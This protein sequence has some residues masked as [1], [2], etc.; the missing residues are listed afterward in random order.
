MA[1]AL[2]GADDDFDHHKPG[3]ERSWRRRTGDDDWDSEL[4]DDLLGEDMLTGKKTQSDMSDEELNDDLLQSDNEEDQHYS[5]QGVTVSLNAASSMVT[6]FELSV[7]ANDPSIEQDSEYEHGEDEIGYDKSDVPEEYAEEYSEG[8]Y[9]GQETELTEDQIGYGEDQGEEDN[10]NDEVLDLE[11]NE[12]LDE[13]PDE[14]F[15]QSY[16]EQQVIKQAYEAEEELEEVVDTQTPPNESEEAVIE[17]LEFQEETKEESDEEE[18]DDEESGR[19]RFKTERKE[20]TI[21]RLSDVTRE[22]RNIPETLELSAEAKAA[23]LEFEE[24]E[25]QLKQGRYGSRRGGRRGG[26]LMCHGLGEQRRDSNERG[27][28]EDHRPALLPTQTAVMTH[29][30][31][32]FRHQQPIRNLFQQRQQQQQPQQQQQQPQGLLPVPT[33]HHI[34]PTPSQGIHMPSQVETPRILMTPPSVASQQPKNIH[35]N[36]HF[37]GTVV[38]PVQVPLL[39]VPTQPRPAVGPQRF[40]GHLHPPMHPQHPQPPPQQH[41]QTSQQHPQP[42]QPHHQTHQSHHHHHL[43]PVPPQPLIPVAPSQFRLHLQT[44]Q[45]Q[46]SGNWMQC[47]QRQGLVKARHNTPTQS[48]VKRPNQQLQSS[49]PRNSNLRELPIA[50]LH[51]IEA[52]NNQRTSAPAAQVKPITSTTPVTRPVTGVKKQLGR[53]ETKPRAVMPMTQPKMEVQSEPEFPDDDEETRLYCLKIEEQKRLREEILKQKELRRQL[54]A[55]ARK[56]ELLER[57]AQQQQGSSGQQQEEDPSQLP[58]NGNPLLSLPG[59]QPRQNVKC[60]L[61]VKKQ[62]PVIPDSTAVQPK[63]VNVLQSGDSVQCQGQQI[64]TIKQLR[65]A[66]T[67][68]KNKF[69][70]PNKALQTK[71]PAAVHLNL[72]EIARVASVQGQPQELKPGL[73]RTVMQRANNGSGDGTHTGTKVRVIKLSG[74]GG[75]N[76]DFSHLEGLPHRLLQPSEQRHQPMRKVTLTKGAVQQPHQPHQHHLSQ[77]QSTF[78]QELKNIPGRHQ[79]KKGILHGRGRGITGQ[80]GRGRLMASKPNLRV[81]ECK[82]QPCIVSVEGL[83]SST[84]D[85]QLKNLLMSVGPIQSLQMLPQQRKA[86]AKF[87]EPADALKFQQKFHRYST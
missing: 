12:P 20:G 22:R 14:G 63:P 70:L 41:P 52:A 67:M 74:G 61:M 60:R 48:I 17:N 34:P 44:S 68:P 46:P 38:T 75:E 39:P 78:P 45:Q 2:G 26:S 66:R 81:V 40:A 80:M 36:P 4:D 69:Q 29:S 15:L 31:R 19:L 84:T 11:I 86:I 58:S 59:A 62:E 8:Q 18:E 50:P 3:A 6:S 28:I 73:K 55:G 76:V 54:Q 72:S 16:S 71:L 9:E 35:I 13:F 33:Q 57:L 53:T 25:R 10:Y 49:T 83:S 24:R 37:K 1:A 51:S 32:L 56:R 87:K 82:P 65:Q 64:K 7:N 23:L 85:I 27:R 79:V 5:T 43:L 77:I 21:I 47:Q 30:E 42:P